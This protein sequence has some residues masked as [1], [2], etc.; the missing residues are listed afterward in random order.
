MD[1]VAE[2]AA[3]IHLTVGEEEF[4]AVLALLEC[5]EDSLHHVGDIDFDS[6]FKSPSLPT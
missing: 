1:K 6:V 5:E 3:L 4:P 2:R